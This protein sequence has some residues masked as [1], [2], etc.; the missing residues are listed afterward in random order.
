[1]RTTSGSVTWSS[2]ISRNFEMPL[3]IWS[4]PRAMKSP[5]MISRIGRY[6][7]S[8]IPDATPKSDASLMGV[9]MTRSGQRAL[10]PRAT[11]KAPP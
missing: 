2:Y 8:A 1:V 9:V 11:L 4:K 10:S 6:P 3:T 5:N 7:R